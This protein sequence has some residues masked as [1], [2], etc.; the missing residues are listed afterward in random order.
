VREPE[1]VTLGERVRWARKRAKLTQVR[2]ATLAGIH[3]DT[4]S[5]WETGKIGGDDVREANL[6]AV[7]PYLKVPVDWLREGGPTPRIPSPG[8]SN[9]VPG[10]PTRSPAFGRREADTVRQEIAEHIRREDRPP[11][12]K[13]L[14]WVERLERRASP[15]GRSRPAADDPPPSP[16]APAAGPP[17]RPTPPPGSA[18]HSAP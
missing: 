9:H 8:A 1:L 13:V 16:P 10:I 4:V 15:P 7:A 18:A 11:W 5:G 14:E 17:R 2:L 12:S 3:K 6:R